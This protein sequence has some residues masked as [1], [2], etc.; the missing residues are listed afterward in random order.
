MIVKNQARRSAGLPQM[1][2]L[3]RAYQRVLHEIVRLGRVPG[4]SAGVAAQSRDFLLK[5][6]VEGAHLVSITTLRS[7]THTKAM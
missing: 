3:E 2:F 7:H 1:L 5:R 6:T 4:Q